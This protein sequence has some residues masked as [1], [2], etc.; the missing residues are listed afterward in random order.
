MKQ[1]WSFA[2]I[3]RSLANTSARLAQLSSK[4]LLWDSVGSVQD[5]VCPFGW[6]GQVWP[7]SRDWFA[8]SGKSSFCDL[9]GLRV[10]YPRFASA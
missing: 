4:R 8:S 6:F 5:M 1:T 10:R 2:G 3:A 7:T 9:A